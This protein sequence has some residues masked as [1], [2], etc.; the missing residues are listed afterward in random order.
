M[1]LNAFLHSG[2]ITSDN[3]TLVTIHMV[4]RFGAIIVGSYL[5]LLGFCLLRR[6]NLVWGGL[7]C[8][9]V[10]LQI[11]LG[12]LNIVLLLPLATAV[13]HN[14]VA[15]LILLL[16]IACLNQAGRKVTAKAD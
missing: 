4:H 2:G 11:S 15:V 12:V 14:L 16:L 6:K 13:T 1:S 7:L 3:L 10:G 8:L 9:G 5:F